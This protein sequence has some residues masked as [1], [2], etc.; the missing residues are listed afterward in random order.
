MFCGLQGLL[1]A[2]C[3][4]NLG[5]AHGSP[6][7]RTRLAAS[8]MTP[9]EYRCFHLLQDSH[10]KLS[11]HVYSRAVTASSTT[12]LDSTGQVGVTGFELAT[13]GLSAHKVTAQTCLRVLFVSA[14]PRRSSL[15]SSRGPGL[16]PRRT[17]SRSEIWSDS[18]TTWIGRQQRDKV[19]L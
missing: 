18:Q 6:S 10:G 16:P 3:G 17:T 2:M 12:V 14:L 19:V 8:A 7:P 5:Q 11:T 15:A 9:G 13:P 1:A 4:G